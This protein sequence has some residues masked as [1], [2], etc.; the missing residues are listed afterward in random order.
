MICVNFLRYYTGSIISITYFLP[1]TPFSALG[2]LSLWTSA[3]ALA[4]VS[5]L[6][7]VFAGGMINLKL[8]R[9]RTGAGQFTHATTVITCMCM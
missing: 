3:G 2:Y 4:V 9:G 6:V 8:R 7:C 5:V 1:L